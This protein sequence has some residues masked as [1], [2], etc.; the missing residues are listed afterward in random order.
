[1]NTLED[2]IF[3]IDLEVHPKTKKIEDI[4]VVYKDREI[5]T[6]SLR[7]LHSFFDTVDTA[8]ICGH[9]IMV[10]DI[11]ILE[12]HGF[13]FEKYHV[14]DT[15]PLSLLLFN[16]K[17]IHSLPKNYKNE[18]D[19]QNNPVEDAKLTKELLIKIEYAFTKLTPLRQNIFYTLLKN[20]QLFSGFFLYLEQKI[21]LRQWSEKEL[22][23]TI[24]EQYNSYIVSKSFLKKMLKNHR[25]E[26]AYIIA[27]LTPQV[28][29]KAHPPKI[30]YDFPNILDLQ[31]KLCFDINSANKEI[32]L[33]A[34]DI[35]GFDSFRSFHR[36]N[37]TLFQSNEISQREMVEA[38]LDDE[39]F[40]CILPTGGGKTF[41][42]WLPA[43]YKASRFKTLTVV[44]SPLQALIEDHIKSFNSKV[45]NFKAVAIS[46]F[47]SPLE[48]SEAIENVVNGEADILYIAPESLR[49]NTIFKILK[50]RFIE[51]FVIDEAHCLS[52][53]GNDF[54]QDYYYICEYIKELLEAKPFQDHIP[55]SCF[56]ATAKPSVI[57][58]IKEYFKEGLGIKLEQYLATPERKNLH[59][60][61]ITT[62]KAYK[63]KELLK[64]LNQ[65]DGAT[66]VYIPSSTKECDNVASQLAMD[67]NKIVKSFHSKLDSQEKMEILQEYIAN[68]ID[69]I[70]AT[71]AFGMGVD[72]ANIVNVIHY[73][74][75]DSLE[76][77]AQE[78]GRGARDENLE[79]YCPILFDEDDL[80][81]HFAS[82][83]R[84]KLTANEINS[85][86]RVLKRSKS[87]VISKTA[88]ELAKEAGWDVE[89]SANDYTTKIKTILLELEREG[90]IQRKRNKTNFF[91]DS[92]AS[93]SM[94]RL[95]KKLENTNY[96]EDEK[97]RLVLVLQTIIGR[98]KVEAVQIDELAYLLGY[99][100][101]D[102]ALAI[103]ELKDMEIL[104]D[105]KDLS[106]EI[107]KEAKTRFLSI[108]K[109]ENLLF[110]YLCSLSLSRVSM[111]ELNE[112]LYQQKA[113][114]K[115]SIELIKVL[116][117][118][119]RDKTNFL[120]TRINREQDLWEFMF[121]DQ[122]L[123]AKE[124]KQKH[125]LAQEL[126][127]LLTKDL[128]ST[129]KEKVVFSLKELRKKLQEDVSYKRIDKT[130]LYLHHL[131]ILE[132]LYGRFINYSPMQIYTQEKLKNK[133]KYTEYKHRLAQHYKNKIESIHIMGEYAKRL[134]KDQNKAVIFLKDYFT[135]PYEKFK[136][137]YKLLKEQLSRP[138]T[139]KRF[140]KIFDAM[141]EVQKEIIED[142]TT[143]AMMILAG[144]GSG[145]TKVLVHK[146]ASLIL[147]ED[148]KPQQFM[149]L[150]FSNTAKY[151][152][153]Y[154]L[155][156]LI[157]SLAQDVEIHT[158]H[159]YALKL[160]ARKIE[161]KN[162]E[163][164]QQAI[165]EATQAITNEEIT[166]P[167]L[168]VLVLDEY[169]D[170]NEQSFAFVKAIYQQADKDMKIIAVGDDDQCIMEYAGADTKYIQQFRKSF[171]TD[172]E[173]HDLFKEYH[174]L[175]NYRSKKSIVGYSNEFAQK[176]TQRYKS[177][178]LYSSS[179]DDGTVIIKNYP[180]AKSLVAPTVT[181]VAN[182]E[183]KQ[184]IAILAYSNDEVMQIYSELKAKRI[185]VRYIINRDEYRLKDMQELYDFNIVLQSYL[186]GETIFKREYFEKALQHIV[187]KYE[188]SSN[189]E[190]VIK[191]I[192]RFLE[193]N[194]IYYLS[195]WLSYLEMIHK[196]DFEND[197]KSIVVSTIHKSKGMEFQKV[198][199][200][201]NTIPTDDEKRRLY[202]VGMTRAKDTLVVLYKGKQSN[203][204]SS[205]A[206]YEED[207]QVYNVN[208]ILYTHI[209]SLEDIYLGFDVHKYSTK[210][211]FLAGM[212]VT[213]EFKDQWNKFCV[214][215]N[216]RIIAVFSKKFQMI[217]Q[218][219][220]QQGFN[221]DEVVIE[222]VVVWFNDVKM[223]N[224]LHPL[225]KIVMKKS[226]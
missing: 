171:G 211:Y 37:A 22:F 40:L 101:S 206:R 9:N 78:A 89:D 111:R 6:K 50:N 36:L 105:A 157:G 218:E 217:I 25:V 133:R 54:R 80:D 167:F 97:Q 193:S 124:I 63:Y 205:Y 87:K 66:L 60:D 84:S 116:L 160:I 141:S 26:L 109:I 59:Y 222:N 199:L 12:A 184:G 45:A 118:G 70:V 5:H 94:E 165:Y 162:D 150:T 191:V 138:M 142:K 62:Q 28:E 53:W 146:I 126:L 187:Q 129:K 90:Y 189:K 158:F 17:S 132:L 30:L 108:V 136:Q 155:N 11:P 104:G 110:E 35:F 85:L 65:T 43:I 207:T 180:F 2:T 52:T 92:I 106:L 34:K 130:L 67:T 19:F 194:D 55:I 74:I 131:K 215:Y 24:V 38:A 3:F 112:Y 42:F 176:I 81:K 135:M 201:I 68:R 47:M 156:Q 159:G 223:K 83:N 173:D 175:C 117:K 140:H 119:W 195:E 41:T 79:A 188:K 88:F 10:F 99:E 197:S 198:F 220:L 139:N 203:I 226:N 186:V 49:S 86:L 98:G 57:N 168:S 29:I 33:F 169:Q 219:K 172:E 64:L 39:S 196:E 177:Q 134:E 46:G 212:K 31:H 76:N 115:N 69:I 166:L 125:L 48:R 179:K 170:I 7:S 202:Y 143:K 183:D 127:E 8:F 23:D 51:R 15:L 178:P 149:M 75:S 225:C 1:M 208:E 73:E 163:L 144:P 154:R 107:R 153:K 102:I 214:V 120:F 32:A 58:D 209:M 224:H 221:F 174:L 56:T 137:R 13:T 122:D 20:T 72:K 93:N 44:I 77:Y 204:K 200:L 128:S 121:K 82:L 123:I 100:K 18:D 114:N 213:I 113:V 16:E 182:E 14:I 71:T 96:T 61:A 192:D 152:F 185:S 95:H 21:S 27:L 181:L 210:N 4:G 164:M 145:K 151:E 103:N 148:V 91:A 216:K 190:L 147:Q 161:D